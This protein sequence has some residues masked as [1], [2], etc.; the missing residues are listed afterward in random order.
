MSEVGEAKNP[1]RAQAANL[2]E[3][4]FYKN[5]DGGVAVVLGA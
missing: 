5:A 1:I 3:G 2:T 4:T